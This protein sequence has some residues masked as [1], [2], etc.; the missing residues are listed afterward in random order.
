MMDW[1]RVEENELPVEYEEFL[2]YD[3]ESR[4]RR[5]G[6]LSGDRCLFDD[7]TEVRVNSKTVT[8]YAEL[9]ASPK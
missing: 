9:I 5:I 2:L 3:K 4:K 8:H 1:I 7:G 6:L